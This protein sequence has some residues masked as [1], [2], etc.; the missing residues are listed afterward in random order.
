[1]RERR[2]DNVEASSVQGVNVGSQTWQSDKES[3]VDREDLNA[4]GESSIVSRLVTQLV[5]EP[6]S[7]PK[8]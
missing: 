1:M 6:H 8:S 4:E 7:S 3:V 2:R 5:L